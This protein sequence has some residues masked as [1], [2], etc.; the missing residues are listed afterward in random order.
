MNG[1]KVFPP[2]IAGYLDTQKELQQIIFKSNIRGIVLD[3]EAYRKQQEQ[4]RKLNYLEQQRLSRINGTGNTLKTAPPPSKNPL[5]PPAQ[6]PDRNTAQ[7]AA[8]AD[9]PPSL[10][11]KLAQTLKEN[12]TQE[13]KQAGQAKN[14][15]TE[16]PSVESMPTIMLKGGKGSFLEDMLNMAKYT[17]TLYKKK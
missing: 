5:Q 16:T 7:E 14:E 6:T 2:S 17:R 1:S 10:K 9:P 4:E 3:G 12:N 8:A 11:E 15:E 13:K